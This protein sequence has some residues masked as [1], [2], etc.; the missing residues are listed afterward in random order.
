MIFIKNNEPALRIGDSIPKLSKAKIETTIASG[1]RTDF[2]NNPFTLLLSLLKTVEN[3]IPKLRE[4]NSKGTIKPMAT[5]LLI[6]WILDNE[7]AISNRTPRE[8]P[9]ILLPVKKFSNFSIKNPLYP[10]ITELRGFN[11]CNIIG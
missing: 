2:I 11:Q 7:P 1:A 8:I 4:I 9:I 10:T 6:N 3:I 5:L